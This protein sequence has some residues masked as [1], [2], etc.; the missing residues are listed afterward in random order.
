VDISE[1]IHSKYAMW[2][3]P[4][5]ADYPDPSD[6]L[7][8]TPG[9]LVAS[10]F[11]NATGVTPSLDSLLTAAQSAIQ[12]ADREIAYQALAKGINNLEYTTMIF[13]PSR[14]LVTSKSVQATINPFTYLDFA[15]IT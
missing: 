11:G 8:S 4:N 7:L 9:G 14:V 6:F 13:Q 3:C 2:F 15:S 1:A 5:S 12:P 10:A